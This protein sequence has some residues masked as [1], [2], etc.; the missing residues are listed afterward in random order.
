MDGEAAL[1]DVQREWLPRAVGILDL[2]HVL[3]RLWQAAHCFHSEK[4]RKAEEFVTHRLRLLFARQGRPGNRWLAALAGTARSAGR[5]TADGKCR[6]P[7][8]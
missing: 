7:L 5:E 8:L 4:S 2:F 1:W 6:D 3:Q